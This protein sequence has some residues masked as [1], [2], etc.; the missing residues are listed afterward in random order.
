MTTLFCR[1]VVTVQLFS[2]SYRLVGEVFQGVDRSE[3]HHWTFLGRRF[4]LRGLN[5]PFLSFKELMTD[6]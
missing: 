2:L 3:Q 6:E 1:S 4:R 5:V